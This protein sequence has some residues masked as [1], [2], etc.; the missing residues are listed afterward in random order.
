MKHKFW[1]EAVAAANLMQNRFPSRAFD[2][3]PFYQWYRK[4][5]SSSNLQ[6]CGT[7]AYVH[8]HIEKRRK[9]ENKAKKKT[10]A[11]YDEHSCKVVISRDVRFVDYFNEGQENEI[12]KMVIVKDE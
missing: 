12:E 10:F 6:K 1:V 11:G 5:T 4:K 7:T 9:L 3:T 2:T 8:I